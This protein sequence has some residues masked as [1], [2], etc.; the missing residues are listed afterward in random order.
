MM[1]RAMD[2]LVNGKES[3][4]FTVVLAHGAFVAMDAPFM[5]AIAHGL[6]GEGIRVARFEFPYMREMRRGAPRRPP[7]RLDVLLDCYRQAAGELGTPERLVIG[8]KSLGG[9]VA[10]MIADEI[11]VA[12]LVCLGY[13]FHPPGK[14]D[15]ERA[16]HLRTL[17]TPTVIL[18]GERDQFGSREEIGAYELSPAIRIA[19]L[20]D[21]EHS[22]VP[23]KR[24]GRTMEENLSAAVAEIVR[25]LG[26]LERG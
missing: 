24:S 19:Y 2:F 3:P 23:R 15:L 10:S 11:G 12:G 21:G 8:G 17:R 14:P 7:D 26:E 1:E 5:E 9:R 20:E 18:Q 25:F 4:G 16:A 22:F 6:A 13:P